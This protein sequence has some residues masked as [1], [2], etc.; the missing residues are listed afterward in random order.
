LGVYRRAALSADTLAAQRYRAEEALATDG[1]AC[2]CLGY[3]V[4]VKIRMDA[5]I[6]RD[7]V[8]TEEGP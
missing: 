1:T 8:R 6:E 7:F 3:E 4:L 5:L 2:T